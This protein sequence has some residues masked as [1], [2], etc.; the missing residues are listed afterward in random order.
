MIQITRAR[1]KELSQDGD[2]ELSPAQES[3]IMVLERSKIDNFVMMF[4]PST[5]LIPAL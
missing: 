3:Y 4:I 5:H 2:D 1:L